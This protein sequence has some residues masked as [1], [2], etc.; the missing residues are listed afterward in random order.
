MKRTFLLSFILLL[1]HLGYSQELDSLSYK[2]ECEEGKEMISN[3]QFS[4][5]LQK[6]LLCENDNTKDIAYCYYKLGQL[7]ESEQYYLK[8]I[9]DDSLNIQTHNRLASIYA[10]QFDYPKCISQYKLLVGLD[11]TNSY[12]HKQLG[13]YYQKANFSGQSLIHFQKAHA[14]NPQ[15]FTVLMK[16]GS[17]YLE[18]D[19]LD[20]AENF[21]KKGIVLDST[22]AKLLM[23]NA[24]LVY[25]QKD[26]EQVVSVLNKCLQTQ[27]DTTAYQYKLLG[28]GAYHTEDYP[29]AIACLQKSL[30][31]QESEV[32]HYYLGLAY[33]ESNALYES[34]KQFEKAISTGI[35]D[36]IDTY[37]TN[38]AKVYEA[39]G[40]YQSSIKAYQTAYSYSKSKVLL[41]YL[42][43]NYDEYYADK[44][45][46]LDYYQ[47]YLAQNDTG[48]HKLMEYSQYRVNNLKE[49][50]H[51]N[52]DTLDE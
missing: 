43:R 18:L 34:G 40:D 45:T 41:Y 46:A 10:Q 21:I 27:E 17:I 16:I 14:L 6:L 30:V 8:A 20:A 38:L 5:A 32:V 12:Y 28:I 29:L 2:Q 9:A 7:K 1:T 35:T 3:Y 50:L 49:L 4:Q 31:F 22:N 44:Q 39:N 23:L 19:Q 25:Q 42:A 51:F 26:Y 33:K 47:M 11:E 13:I 15:D 52:I 37:Y 48:H 24:K 36:H